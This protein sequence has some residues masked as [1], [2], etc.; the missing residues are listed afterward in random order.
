MTFMKTTVTV[1]KRQFFRAVFS[2]LTGHIN[3]T[4]L[5][6]YLT[7]FTTIG[8]GIHEYSTTERA[9][10]ADGK[11]QARKTGRIGKLRRVF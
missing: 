10:N 5:G 9:R 1:S 6:Y 3:G 7:H 8:A 4:Y 11:F 2:Y